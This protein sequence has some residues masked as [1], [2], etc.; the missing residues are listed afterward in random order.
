MCTSSTTTAVQPNPH[1]VLRNVIKL[2]EKSVKTKETRLLT[3]RLLR[4][5]ATLRKHL[6]PELL[7]GFVKEFL[8][9]DLQANGL[10]LSQ[11]DKLPQSSTMQTDDEVKTEV[12]SPSSVIPEIEV[13]FYLLFLIYLTDNKQYEL[14][15]ETSHQ[16]LARLS[17]FNR[18]TLDVIAARIC[19][20]YSWSHECTGALEDI[21]SNLLALHRTAVLRHDAIGQET[22][23]A[24]LLR[25]Y[26]HYNLYD[27]AEKFRS[28]AQR[29]EQWRSSAQYCRY[30]YYLGR[31]RTIQLEYTDAKECL[32][33]AARKAPS[34]ASGF[35]IEVN[36]WLILVR[37][38]LG[39]IPDRPEF[40]QPGMK[41]ALQPYFELTQ[42]V[43]HGDLTAFAE[44]AKKNDAVFRADGTHNLI[45]RLHH[46]VIRTG[47]RRINLAYSRISLADVAQKLCL[48]S[49]EDAECIVA[50]AIRDGAIDAIIDHEGGFLQS[51][52]VADVYSTAEPQSAFHARIAF[53]LDIHNDAIKAM[54][55]EPDAHKKKLESAEAR[56]ERLTQEQELAKAIQDD[57]EE[58]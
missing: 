27:Q 13:Y 58:F 25:N 15:K 32:Q 18:R 48:A 34:V 14:A 6:T 37:L 9:T 41:G 50:K 30:L 35:R 31:I 10:L 29:A 22:L 17:A 52:D 45:T 4:Q 3:G 16:A 55:F 38:L 44:V 49:K 24:L 33:Q 23:L 36:K 28:K 40:A 1:E 5:T 56:K 11:L 51:R 53:C 2:L 21:R 43:R 19:F 39:E 12:A 7:R 8:P 42:A 46:N 26:L 20:Y 54:R 47:L 57:D